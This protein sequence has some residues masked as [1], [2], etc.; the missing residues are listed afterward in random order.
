MIRRG[1]ASVKSLL[2]MVSYSYGINAAGL[3]GDG[4]VA[5]VL[6]I[7]ARARHVRHYGP[8]TNIVSRCVIHP[9]E[10]APRQCHNNKS[11]FWRRKKQQ[12]RLVRDTNEIL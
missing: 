3:Y 2:L 9:H 1:P 12:Q 5:H 7:Q 10:P 11:I 6:L 8:R 4:A